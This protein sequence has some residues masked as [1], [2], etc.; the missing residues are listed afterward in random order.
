MKTRKK[1]KLSMKTD[2]L[3][4]FGGSL[5]AEMKHKNFVCEIK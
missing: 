1:K 3:P 5:K 2:L 4:G